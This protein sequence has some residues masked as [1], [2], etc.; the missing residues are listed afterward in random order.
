MQGVLTIEYSQK[1]AKAPRGKKVAA[2][3]AT[4]QPPPQSTVINLKKLPD[5]HVQVSNGDIAVSVYK[6]LIHSYH[7]E[8]IISNALRFDDKN[9]K[10][11]TL[12]VQ[13]SPEKQIRNIPID[14][15]LNI[16][17][18]ILLFSILQPAE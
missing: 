5:N 9:I 7:F 4:P 11:C 1:A 12:T 6:D 17:E 16:D 13:D 3:T 2:A 15:K 10:S 8:Y 14:P 18:A